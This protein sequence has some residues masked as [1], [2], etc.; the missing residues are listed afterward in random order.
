MVC[1]L[2]RSQIQKPTQLKILLQLLQ[3]MLVVDPLQQLLV[4]W[5]HQVWIIRSVWVRQSLLLQPKTSLLMT[6]SSRLSL[7]SQT[8]PR[9]ATIMSLWM[10]FCILFQLLC[11]LWKQSTSRLYRRSAKAAMWFHLSRCRLSGTRK[12]RCSGVSWKRIP[13]TRWRVRLLNKIRQVRSSLN[14]SK[15]LLKET[16]RIKN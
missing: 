7:R 12:K 13:S 4:L 1:N 5:D 15:N 9:R 6:N 2:Q 8:W 11:P 10:T 14:L 3:T 16:I